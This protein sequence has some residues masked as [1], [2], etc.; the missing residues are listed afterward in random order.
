M[1]ADSRDPEKAKNRLGRC[2]E[3]T[4]IPAGLAVHTIRK[5]FGS[6]LVRSGVDMAITHKL[7]RHRNIPTTMRYYIW[8]GLDTLREGLVKSR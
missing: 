7:M 5:T 6:R 4:K 2:V 1:I 8:F 3:R